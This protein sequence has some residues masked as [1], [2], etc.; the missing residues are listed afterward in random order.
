MIDFVKVGS[1]ITKYRK[2][3]NLTQ[4]DI[5]DKL[6]ITRQNYSRWETGE[7]LVPLYHLNSLAN[8]FNSS[9][10]FIIGLTNINKPTE[11]TKKL[12][13]IKIGKRIEEIRT[14]ENLSMRKLAE[15]LNT[16]H[17]TISAYENGKNLIIISFAIELSKKYDISLDWLC[18][19]SNNKYI[20]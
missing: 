15:I 18:G 6:N 1:K 14:D 8:I 12:N 17:S 3:Q 9:M 11:S 16:S 10:D 4:D 13:L 5:A 2:E 7:Q 20:K 19:R